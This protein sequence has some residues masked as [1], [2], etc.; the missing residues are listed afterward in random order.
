MGSRHVYQQPTPFTVPARFRAG[1]FLIAC[2]F[3]SKDDDLVLFDDSDVP[4]GLKR[5]AQRCSNRRLM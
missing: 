3:F 4:G 2:S 5:D 1:R